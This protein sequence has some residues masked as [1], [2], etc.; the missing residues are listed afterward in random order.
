MVIDRQAVTEA[1]L[2]ETGITPAR[3]DAFVR[4]AAF[5]AA[6][7]VRRAALVEAV[8][9]AMLPEPPA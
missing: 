5:E 1:L 6:L 8:T 7:D 3:I 2:A 4:D 9:A